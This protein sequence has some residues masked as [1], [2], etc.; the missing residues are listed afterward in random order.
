M[1]KASG[2]FAAVV[3]LSASM[4]ASFCASAQASSLVSVMNAHKDEIITECRKYGIWPSLV[5]G[6]AG[7]ESGVDSLSGLAASYNNY[8]GHTYSPV[9]ASKIPG[10]GTVYGSFA[11]YPSFMEGVRAHLMW[12]WQ[13]GYGGVQGVLRNLSSSPGD[14]YYAVVS[15][16]YMANTA[17][18]A[19]GIYRAAA[20]VGADEWDKEAFPDGRKFIP[21]IEG[22][23]CSEQ[24]G[25]YDYPADEYNPYLEYARLLPETSLADDGVTDNVDI[26]KAG[27]DVLSASSDLPHM[28]SDLSLS[29]GEAGGGDVEDEGM[30]I[31]L[32]DDAGESLSARCR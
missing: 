7:V 13:N 4:A 31:D 17:G 1:K 12:F 20:A 30:L 29:D 27:S 25:E 6:M 3:L 14:A 23:P 19:D 11:A 21:F 16:G 22:L 24:V 5:V 18:Y 26:E 8:W 9:I 28:S 15:S 2:K 10:T 32:P